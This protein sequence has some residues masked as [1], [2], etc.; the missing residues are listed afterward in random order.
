M[1]K[2]L[3]ID[4]DASFLAMLEEYV[5]E[6][7]PALRVTTCADPVKGLGAISAELDLL[8]VDLEMPGIDG[9]KILAYATAQGLSKTRV[10]ILSGRHADYLHQRFPMGSCLAVLNKYEVKQKAVLEMIFGSLQRQCG[11]QGGNC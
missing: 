6:N 4:D 7:F 2:I 1:K 5:R 9:S 11:Q 10:I 3:I 8:L